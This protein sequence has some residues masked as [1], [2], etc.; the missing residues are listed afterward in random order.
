LK[1]VS[2]DTVAR[3][4]KVA[5]LVLLGL[6]VAFYSMLA[7]GE[8]VGGDISGIQHLPPALTLGALSWVAWRRP[9]TAG[10]VLLVLAVPLGAAY[11]AFLVVRELPLTLWLF[12]ALPPFVTGLLLVQAGRGERDSRLV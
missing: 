11:L 6:G 1:G 12:I 5:A 7:F 3:R 8:M 10:I 2:V 4:K 9:L